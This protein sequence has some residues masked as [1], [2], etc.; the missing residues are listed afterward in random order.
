MLLHAHVNRLTL[1]TKAI[2]TEL[3]HILANSPKL[4]DAMLELAQSQRWLQTSLSVSSSSRRFFSLLL[5]SS[6]RV[7]NV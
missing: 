7:E 6:M 5:S 3:T 4:L 2:K 1:P